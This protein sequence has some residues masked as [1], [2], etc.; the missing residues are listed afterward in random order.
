MD[1]IQSK[2]RAIRYIEAHLTHD[3]GVRDVAEQVYASNS[4]F[5]R[6]FHLVTGITIGD[7]I[8]NRRLSLAESKETHTR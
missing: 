5:Q 1:W 3:I 2:T 8:R 7:Y 6:I 4:H